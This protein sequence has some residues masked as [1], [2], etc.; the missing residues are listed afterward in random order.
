MRRFPA[1]GS[2]S[3]SGKGDS[4]PDC[5]VFPVCE[6]GGRAAVESGVASAYFNRVVVEGCL[7]YREQREGSEYCV[8]GVGCPLHD[9]RRVVGGDG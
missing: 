3:G 2:G 4:L 6:V 5:Y 7:G 1:I 9:G 8:G